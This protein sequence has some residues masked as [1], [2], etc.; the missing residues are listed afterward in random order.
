MDVRRQRP[1]DRLG[2]LSKSVFM[3]RAV[4]VMASTEASSAGGATPTRAAWVGTAADQPAV[5]PVM[6]IINTA[7]HETR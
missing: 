2:C 1:W 4:A 3:A 6:P 7:A 5:R